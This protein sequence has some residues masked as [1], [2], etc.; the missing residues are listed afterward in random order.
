MNKYY[1]AESFHHLEL[2]ETKLRARSRVNMT[3]HICSLSG[4][5]QEKKFKPLGIFSSLFQSFTPYKLDL[6]T[7]PLQL[8]V[9]LSAT[10]F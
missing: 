7:L 5:K 9:F 10:L 1:G 4:Q 2:V 8:H 3:P 6:N